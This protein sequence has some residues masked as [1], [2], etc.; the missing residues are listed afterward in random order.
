MKNL[1]WVK[2]VRVIGLLLIAVGG[3]SMSI[4][5]AGF[6]EGFTIQWF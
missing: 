3:G 4:E 5:I 1:F 6:I 2:I